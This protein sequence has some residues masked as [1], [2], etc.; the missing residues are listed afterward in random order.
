MVCGESVGGWRHLSDLDVRTP[1]VR[2]EH[3]ALWTEDI[4]RLAG[5]YARYFGASVSPKY[6]N[7]SKGYE[8][9]FLTF[10]DGARLELMK[11]TM[12]RPVT[13]EPGVER[14]GLTHL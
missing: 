13:H 1:V 4:D 10:E 3:V 6:T 11:T 14:M 12:L 2:I 9:Y 5:F 7:P 8:S